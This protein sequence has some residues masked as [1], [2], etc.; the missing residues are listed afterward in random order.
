MF[1]NSP[2]SGERTSNIF[3]G[4]IVFALFFCVMY[5]YRTYW[6]NV[7]LGGLCTFFYAMTTPVYFNLAG[8][9]IFPT[10]EAHS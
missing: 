3:L 1:A 9:I 7:V 5:F 6:A 10:G 4:L 2:V 8:E